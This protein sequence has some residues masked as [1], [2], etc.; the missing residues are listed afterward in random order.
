MNTTAP[1]GQIFVCVACGKLS[2]DRYGNDKVSHGWDENCMMSAILCRESHL[3]FQDG[4]V[5][6]V[7]EG[8]VVDPTAPVL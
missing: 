6:E 7:K 1:Q 8:G 4:R 5:I 3:V 2:R